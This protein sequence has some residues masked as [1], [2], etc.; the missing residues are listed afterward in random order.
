MGLGFWGAKL[1]TNKL[2]ETLVLY[3]SKKIERLAQQM[4]L[5]PV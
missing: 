3:D 5:S 1:L 4:N 2:E